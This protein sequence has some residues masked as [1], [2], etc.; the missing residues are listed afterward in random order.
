MPTLLAFDRQEPQLET[1]VSNVEDMKSKKFLTEWIERE[2]KRAG[3]GGG[4]GS[5]TSLFGGLFGSR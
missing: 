4:G 5:G 1:R 2:A 3:S